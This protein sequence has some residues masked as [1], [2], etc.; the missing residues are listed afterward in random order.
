MGRGHRLGFLSIPTEPHTPSV[1]GEVVRNRISPG[2]KKKGVVATSPE[3]RVDFRVEDLSA[4]QPHRFRD[5]KGGR[6]YRE[7]PLNCLLGRGTKRVAF[8]SVPAAVA[9]TLLKAGKIA[10]GWIIAK[11]VLPFRRRAVSVRCC[12]R[13]HFNSLCPVHPGKLGET[14]ERCFRCGEKEHR[15]REC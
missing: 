2:S 11:I 5:F 4:N 12:D 7:I 3:K 1:K 8:L 14:H 9:S 13:G 6:L 10:I 15:A